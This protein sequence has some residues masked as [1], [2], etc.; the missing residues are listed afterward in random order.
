MRRRRHPFARSGLDHLFGCQ[1][2]AAPLPSRDNSRDGEVPDATGAGPVGGVDRAEHL[3]RRRRGWALL[4]CAL[5][6][7]SGGTIPARIRFALPGAPRVGCDVAAVNDPLASGTAT[8][9]PDRSGYRAG[10]ARQRRYC[11][12]LYPRDLHLAADHER[13]RDRR[14]CRRCRGRRQAHRAHRLAVMDA[15]PVEDSAT[16]FHRPMATCPALG[17]RTSRTPPGFSAPPVALI[18]AAVLVV[19]AD[20]GRRH[21]V[22]LDTKP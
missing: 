22:R 8:G 6:T 2:V 11:G 15:D 3:E 1:F 4:F 5:T 13:A 9:V 7:L 17:R 10:P 19:P 21:H 20:C 12:P 14:F 18:G 16:D